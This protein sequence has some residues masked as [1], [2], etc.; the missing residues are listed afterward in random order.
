MFKE[1]NDL[2][3]SNEERLCRIF[4]PKIKRDLKR[5]VSDLFSSEILTPLKLKTLD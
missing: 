3:D 4:K 1:L 5:F 2:D